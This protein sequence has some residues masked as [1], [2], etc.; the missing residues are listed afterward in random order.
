[1]LKDFGQFWLAC[2]FLI[3]FAGIKIDKRFFHISMGIKSI[4]DYNILLFL[5]K[6]F[7]FPPLIFVGHHN[8]RNSVDS[9]NYHK[10]HKY[11]RDA[12]ADF[13]PSFLFQNCTRLY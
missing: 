3:D 10:G 7:L 2:C 1:M 8:D 11:R 9:L 12:F 5:C 6:S 4:F 13:Y